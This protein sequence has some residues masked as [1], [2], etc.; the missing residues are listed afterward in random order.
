M[1]DSG[2][3][4]QYAAIGGFESKDKAQ[5]ELDRY[6]SQTGLDAWVWEKK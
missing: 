2:K 3:G 6:K 1:V 5:T 4:L